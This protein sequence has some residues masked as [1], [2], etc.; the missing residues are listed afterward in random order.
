MA[1]LDV[2]QQQ[3]DGYLSVQVMNRVAEML[4]VEKRS[5]S[6]RW[7]RSTPCSTARRWAST[8]SWWTGRRRAC[9]GKPTGEGAE[10]VPGREEVREHSRRDVLA[11]EME[12]MGCCVNAP[13]IAVAD[14]TDGV[15]GYSYNYYEDL[16]PEDAVAVV[17]R[18]QRAGQNRASEASTG[19]RRNPRRDR[20]RSRANPRGRTAGTS[21]RSRRSSRR[22]AAGGGQASRG[23]GREE[24]EFLTA[25]AKGGRKNERENALRQPM[26]RASVSRIPRVE[27][28]GLFERKGGGGGG[29]G[30]GY[31]YALTR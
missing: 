29:G 10:R 30:G 28:E 17:K 25:S 11:R 1:S 2:A 31:W 15:A 3:N 14:Y 21:R 8:T 27:K 13:T 20:R 16:T 24:G 12:C 9:S 26:R 23:G 22:P 5:A 6:T 18:R 19:I 7:R 4:E